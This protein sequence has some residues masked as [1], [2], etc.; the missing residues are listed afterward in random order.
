MIRILLFRSLAIVTA[1]LVMTGCASKSE[2]DRLYNYYYPKRGKSVRSAFRKSFDEE[3]FK[4]RPPRRESDRGRQLYYAFRGDP[5]AFHAFMHN[6]DRDEDTYSRDE[7]M[8][9]CLLLLLRLGDD[10]FAELLAVEDAAAREAAG[11]AIESQIDWEKHQ[12]PKTR[13][14]YKYRR[15]A[16]PR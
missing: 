2:F 8:S 16:A 7:W 5:P 12:F 11:V 15:R 3:L 1:A 13:E 10:R 9:E 4:K 6:P 14:L